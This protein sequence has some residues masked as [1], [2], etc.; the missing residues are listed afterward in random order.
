LP[1]GAC[2]DGLIKLIEA[3]LDRQA[4]ELIAR[5]DVVSDSCYQI[6]KT[7]IVYQH[8]VLHGKSATFKSKCQRVA[9]DNSRA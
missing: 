4:T 3:D 2:L 9:L 7:A 6:S 8:P 5:P 1:F